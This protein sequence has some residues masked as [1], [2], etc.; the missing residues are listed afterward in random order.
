MWSES[1]RSHERFRAKHGRD[2]AN[3]S[4]NLS[5]EI[6]E[7][8]IHLTRNLDL[9]ICH[10]SGTLPILILIVAWYNSSLDVALKLDDLAFDCVRNILQFNVANRD[11]QKEGCIIK[12]TD[13]EIEL[14][15]CRALHGSR[16]GLAFAFVN[17]KQVFVVLCSLCHACYCSEAHESK[18]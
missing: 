16:I 17:R 10:Q 13:G 4:R 11:G 15:F 3:G 6:E 2:I 1:E 7:R 9:G 12:V 5:G 14:A 18:E 8:A